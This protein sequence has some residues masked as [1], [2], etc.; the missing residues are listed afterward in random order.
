MPTQSD[1]HDTTHAPQ[2]S[3][4][5]GVGDKLA[6]EA[7]LIGLGLIA[8]VKAIQDHP[9][10]TGINLAVSAGIGVGLGLLTRNPETGAAAFAKSTGIILGLS[11]LP[12]LAFNGM[13]VGSALKDTWQSSQN[14]DQNVRSMQDG[15]GTL[16]LNAAFMVA[17]GLAT[18]SVLGS[19]NTISSLDLTGE[20]PVISKFRP[21]ANDPIGQLHQKSLDTV[22]RITGRGTPE[23]FNAPM[24][25]G[26]GAIVSPDGKVLTAFHVIGDK[27]FEP[28]DAERT[29]YSD[30]QIHLANGKSYPAKFIGGTPEL[31]LAVL[32]AVPSR[33]TTFKYLPLAD[34][35]TH[36]TVVAAMGFP[37]KNPGLFINQGRIT[38]LGEYQT[39]STAAALDGM[40]GGPVTD[41]PG[42]INTIVSVAPTWENMGPQATFQGPPIASI[43]TLI[44]AMPKTIGSDFKPIY[45]PA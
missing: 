39:E 45:V 23:D 3:A 24:D 8:P 36:G 41:V 7:H 43:H 26:S 28:G 40:S 22:V 14:W 30:L 13:K 31:D 2:T 37:Q 35:S 9:V 44:D 16:E 17:G 25:S 27:A 32:Q 11:A 29:I 12:M 1:I 20:K 18:R 42:K 5:D 38:D 6:R 4:N 10:E 34:E 33:S 19:R 15:L 21:D